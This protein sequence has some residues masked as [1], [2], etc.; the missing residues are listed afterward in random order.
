MPMYYILKKKKKKKNPQGAKYGLGAKI[1]QGAKAQ[2][3]PRRALFL[4]VMHVVR[5]ESKKAPRL[6]PC[7]P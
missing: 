2:K 5:L 1:P 7:A 4:G 6:A 3:A